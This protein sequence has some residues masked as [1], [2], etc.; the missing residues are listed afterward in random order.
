MSGFLIFTNE[1]REGIQAQNP[2][3]KMTEISKALGAAW[4]SMSDAQKAPYNQRNLE[5]KI[6]Y[7]KE[8][9]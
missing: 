1:K 3:M 4:N 2:D 6:R 8:L 5:D 9:E 7:E